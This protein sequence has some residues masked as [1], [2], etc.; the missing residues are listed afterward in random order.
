MKP[1]IEDPGEGHRLLSFLKNSPERYTVYQPLTIRFLI[2]QGKEKDFS[3]YENEIIFKIK[4]LVF[5]IN[6]STSALKKNLKSLTDETHYTWKTNLV[7][8]D[9]VS[10][11]SIWKLNQNE[12][13]ES[14]IQEILN[15]CNNLIAEFHVKNVLD[16]DTSKQ[17]YFIYAGKEGKWYDEFLKIDL[18]KIIDNKT[19]ST[20]SIQ[21]AGI[22]YFDESTNF[23]L[24]TKTSDV[25]S[26]LK[27]GVELN[28][29]KN[30]K[31]GDI[32]AIKKNNT[33]GIANIGIVIKEYYFEDQI[34]SSLISSDKTTYNHR[35]GVTYLNI[36]LPQ[37]NDGNI[38]GIYRAVTTKD[39]ILDYLRRSQTESK[40]YLLRHNIDGPWKDDLGKKY[41]FGKT[42]PNHKKLIEA[43]SGTKTIWFT[44]LSGE[45]YFWGYGTVNEIETI[46]ENVEWNLLYEN[47]KYFPRNY[48]DSIAARGQFLKKANDTIK[49]EIE[50]LSNYNQQTSMFPITKK[51]YEQILSED[52]SHNND[53]SKTL[54][55]NQY[56]KI[57]EFNKNL[58]LYGPPG[59][60][61]TF[62]AEE[63]ASHITADQN[64]KRRHTW[65]TITSLVLLENN[66]LPLNYHEIAKRALEKN[67]VHTI[68]STPHETLAK[69]IREDIT[70]NDE[71]SFFI[72]TE[73]GIYGLN[74]PFTFKKASEFILFANNKSMKINDI[75]TQIIQH[76]LVES[77]GETPERTLSTEILRDY[78]T[79]DNSTFIKLDNGLITLRGKSNR[80]QSINNNNN[81]IRKVTFHPSYSYEDFIEGFR[82]NVEKQATDVEKQATDASAA[83]TSQPYVLADGIF[84]EIC[85][86]AKNDLENNYVLIIDEIN[87]GNIPK[88]FGEL[89][90]VIEN[91]Y[92]GPKYERALAYSKNKDNFYVPTNLYIIATMNTADKSLVQMDEALRRRFIFEELMPEPNLLKD[93]NRPGKKYIDILENINKKIIE[94]DNIKQFRD[95]QIGHS[96]FWNDPFGDKE[97]RLVIKYQIFP[98]LQ[99]YFYDDYDEIRRILGDKIIDSDNRLG[100]I[101]NEGKETELIQELR[102]H[103]KSKKEITNDTDNLNEE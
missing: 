82:P 68:A 60:G 50:N 98:L 21:T 38:R 100:K 71:I 57:L 84:K 59:T 53:G 39:V 89:I 80:P 49:Q 93:N 14:Q 94:G 9:D 27:N 13:D 11:P 36:S 102:T 77:I 41:H 23:D 7:I 92:R 85:N 55:L 40:Y 22:S 88:I 46:Q 75:S 45:F 25:I 15:E 86:E 54:N 48:D 64:N 47:F 70:V 2:E 65:K 97:L 95:R 26:K 30:I 1:T 4:S 19:D 10:N 16:E 66:G 5:N 91:G 31:K 24:N 12:F 79:G 73:D 99:D 74:L 17:I 78:N 3:M 61:K 103:L 87:R 33:D 34:D 29:I 35:I 20:I 8:F 44:K 37:I 58:I 90:T 18:K 32:V 69:I 76:N 96:F 56:E 52:L 72:K 67:L 42:V 43:G 51:I 63:I 81:F 101:L 62:M 28:L 83:N 6:I